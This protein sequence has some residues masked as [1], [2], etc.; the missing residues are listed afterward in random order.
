[1]DEQNLAVVGGDPPVATVVI[2]PADDA[3]ALPVLE[4]WAPDVQVVH[5]P[6]PR[7]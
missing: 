5:G 4:L 6:D 1:V 3:A 2:E 7:V